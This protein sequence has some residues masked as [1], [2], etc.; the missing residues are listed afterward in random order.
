VFLEVAAKHVTTA[1]TTITTAA[2]TTNPVFGFNSALL[3]H[4]VAFYS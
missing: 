4:S 3:L 2:V 1:R